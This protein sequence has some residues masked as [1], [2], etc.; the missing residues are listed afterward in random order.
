V[1]AY[2]CRRCPG[3]KMGFIL[4]LVLNPGTGAPVFPLDFSAGN[5][6]PLCKAI[7]QPTNYFVLQRSEP[8]GNSLGTDS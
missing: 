3:C 5:S 8:L 1:F 4:Q 2:F 7:F 6:C